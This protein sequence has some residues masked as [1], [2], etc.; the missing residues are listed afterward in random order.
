MRRPEAVVRFRAEMKIFET[1]T[2][3]GSVQEIWRVHFETKLLYSELPDK[4]RR[5]YGTRDRQ[6][7]DRPEP[8]ES[9][10]GMFRAY[11]TGDDEKSVLPRL[12]PNRVTS[13]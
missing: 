6:E 4:I 1:V 13:G 2:K 5:S 9:F 7:Q 12:I 8:R 3:L 10:A 11:T